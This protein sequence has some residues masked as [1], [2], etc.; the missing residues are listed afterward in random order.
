MP[1]EPTETGILFTAFEPSGDDHASAV[2]RELRRRYPTLPIYA[3]G[4]PKMALAGA[5]VVQRTGEHA[6]IGL[7]GWKVIQ[8]YRRIHR[9]IREWLMRHPQVRVHVPVDSPAANFPVCEITK[10]AGRRVVHLVAPQLW[11][12]GAWRLKKLRRLSDL[13]LCILP[14]EEEWF[15]KRGV[16]ARFIG[17]PLFDEPLDFEGL[18]QRAHGLPAGEPRLALLPGSRPAELRRNFPLLLD[19]YRALRAEYPG[20]CGVVA[21]TT[22]AARERLYAAA[23]ERGGW[24]EGLDIRVGQT[25]VVVRWCQVALAVS[26]TVTLQVAKQARPMVIFYKASRL[27]YMLLGRWLLTTECLAL[28]NLIAQREICRELIP[29]FGDA[30]RLISA[31]E[32]LL[33]DAPAQDAQRRDLLTIVSKF[34]G[35]I[36]SAEA[37]DA[38]AHIA[39]LAP[40]SR[41]PSSLSSALPAE[42]AQKE[43]P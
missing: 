16:R 36:A 15:A 23:N 17:H 14:F 19:S 31:A 7:P 12:W 26:G 5:Q 39:D 8:Q 9:D 38:I 20:L 11:A 25:D 3:W 32:T 27:M 13:V 22:D 42:R 18:D 29:Y 1:I 28:P 41:P 21:A 40:Q 33:R 37:A 43:S 2:I 4:G 34:E 10:R 24:P 6:V 35:K 30:G